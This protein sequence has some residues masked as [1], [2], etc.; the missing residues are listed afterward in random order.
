MHNFHE[1]F[2]INN[3]HCAVSNSVLLILDKLFSISH[4][5]NNNYV[6][7]IDRSFSNSLG[8]LPPSDLGYEILLVT[9]VTD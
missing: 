5:P 8:S 4:T 7:F 2:S 9:L 3:C 6:N 1:I